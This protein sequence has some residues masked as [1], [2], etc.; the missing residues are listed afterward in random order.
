MKKI[1]MLI[2]LVMAVVGCEL[3]SP[4]YWNRVDRR[5]EEKGERCYRRSD[6]NMYCVDKNGNRTY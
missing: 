6:G 1:I 4:D 5:M 3:V 2:I